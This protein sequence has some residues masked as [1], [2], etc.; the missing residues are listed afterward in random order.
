MVIHPILIKLAALAVRWKWQLIAAALLL[1]FSSLVV[2]IYV[3]AQ[4]P[5]L[6]FE[7]ARLALSQARQ[8][9]AGRYLPGVLK[10]AEK[11]WEQARSAWQ[12]ETRKW[13]FSRDYSTARKLAEISRDVSRHAA[14]SA[15]AVKD[16]LRWM[17]AAQVAIVKQK[18]AEFR[19]Q[20]TDIPIA[21][22]DRQKFV[23]GE[24]LMMESELAFQ[25]HDFV[26][27]AARIQAAA[28][29]VGGANDKV[30]SLLKSCLAKIPKWHRMAAE[31]IAW[32]KE[33]DE[34]VIIVD[35][36][37]YRCQI[38]DDG[39]LKAE[40][41]IELGPNWLGHKRKKG[42]GA[43]PEG[44]YRVIKK[45]DIKKSI[46]Y[47]A[48]EIDY[49]ND[50]DLQLFREAR[51]RGEIPSSAH[52]GGS[53]EIHGEG[54]KGVNWTSGCVALTNKNMDKVFDL[55]KVGTPVTIVGALDGSVF[56]E[57]ISGANGK[58]ANSA[59]HKK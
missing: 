1:V 55:A 23:A 17:A 43:T 28:S 30:I 27:A 59:K 53:I 58:A 35:K 7:Q 24:L 31:T 33:H 11:Q 8:A 57:K 48:L 39:E 54:G 49:P 45:K 12:Q 3:S 14:L 21:N 20:F 25:R 13:V 10:I 41:P 46:Y 36:M 4:T 40:F 50:R 52:I 22:G 56:L 15:V 5:R 34:P 32:S 19:S 37:G 18:I 16:S 26:L 47:K 2:T 29:Y 44:Q 38:Y 6:T 51:N 42:D 9:E